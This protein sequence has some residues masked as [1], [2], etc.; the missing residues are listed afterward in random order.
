MQAT[1]TTTVSTPVAR[2]WE[3]LADHEGMAAWGPGMKVTLVRDGAPDR[4]GVGAQRRLQIGPGPAFVEEVTAFEPEQRLTYK[5]IAGIPLRNY[6]GDVQLRSVNG[7]TE[8]RYS[9]SADNRIP[10][11][12]AALAHGLLFAFKRQV[13]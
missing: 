1:A 13:K 5:A 3:V 4:N 2:V 8:I 7:G 12:A 10:G 11:A 9:V 6:V